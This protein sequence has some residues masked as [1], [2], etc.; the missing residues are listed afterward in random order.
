MRARILDA[1]VKVLREKGYDLR[2][3]FSRGARHVDPR[4]TEATLPGAL[5]WLWS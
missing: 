1:S 5:E 2:F 4:V 3:T